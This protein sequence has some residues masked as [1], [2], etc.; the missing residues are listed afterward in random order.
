[1]RDIIQGTIDS[2]HEAIDEAD[3]TASVK[4]IERVLGVIDPKILEAEV[5][6]DLEDLRSAIA[7]YRGI[8]RAGLTPEEYQEEKESAFEAIK[9][10]V[11]G[12]DIDEDALESLEAPPVKE[13][14]QMTRKE[15]IKQDLER[16][17]KDAKDLGFSF[18]EQ[19]QT[20][21]SGEQH[22]KTVR[23][24]LSIGKP[25]PPEVLKDYPDLVSTVKTRRE[26]IIEIDYA[27]TLNEL[28]RMAR[29]KGVSLSGTKHA[30]IARLL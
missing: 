21:L 11:D 4:R 3:K 18:N 16:Y 20:K 10:A 14:W 23:K 7:D 12:L 15:F 30:I 17:R 26:Q 1:M 22:E 19:L 28:K 24:A 13:T 9:E 5:I 6:T 8:T 27:H 25:V 2:I 29:E